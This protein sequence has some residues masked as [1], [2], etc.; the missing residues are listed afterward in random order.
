MASRALG[1]TCALVAALLLTASLVSPKLTAKLPAWWDGAPTVLG[2]VRTQQSVHVGPL[3]AAGCNNRGCQT[4]ESGG[5]EVGYAAAGLIALTIVI[6]VL[7][8]LATWRS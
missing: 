1:A 6:A 5:K 2:K 4:I 7:V 8:A 3:G